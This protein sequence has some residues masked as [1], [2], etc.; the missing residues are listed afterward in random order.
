MFINV[1]L[2]QRKLMV[3]VDLKIPLLKEGNDGQSP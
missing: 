1:R 3:F 2:I